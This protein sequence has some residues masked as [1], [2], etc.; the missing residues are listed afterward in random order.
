[1]D[2][3]TLNEIYFWKRRGSASKYPWQRFLNIDF[4][5]TERKRIKDVGKWRVEYFKKK[6]GDTLGPVNYYVIP[7][8]FNIP[9]KVAGLTKGN[10][11]IIQLSAL[12]NCEQLPILM[13]YPFDKLPPK[14]YS[15]IRIDNS[16]KD[17]I[18]NPISGEIEWAVNTESF[19]ELDPLDIYVDIPSERK[20]V[21]KFFKENLFHEENVAEAFQLPVS[22]AP[23]NGERGGV[24]LSYN[25]SGYLGPTS[26][27]LIKIL[28]F[29]HPPEMIDVNSI[30]PKK[31]LKGINIKGISFKDGIS[32]FSERNFVGKNYSSIFQT[33]NLGRLNEELS[34]RAKFQGEYSIS[35]DISRA[36]GES[37]TDLL[38]NILARFVRTESNTDFQ[39]AEVE[40]DWDKTK[41]LVGEDLWIQIANQRQ[42]PARIVDKDLVLD[43]KSKLIHQTKYILE[44]LNLTKKIP[45]EIGGYSKKAADNVLKIAQALARDENKKNVDEFILKKAYNIFLKNS[46]R[47]VSNENIQ[48]EA[49]KV[50]D[51]EKG[52]WEDRRCLAIRAE[53][54]IKD[55][56]IKDIFESVGYLFNNNLLELENFLEKLKIVNKIYEPISNFYR[57]VE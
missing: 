6:I 13:I 4:L 9:I 33:P 46:D 15:L 52:E 10:F 8:R 14:D 39:I 34:K 37:S 31:V 25:I 28:K 29:I 1:M 24:S 48:Y 19:E 56:Y 53:T 21:F 32:N 47:L 2:A 42:N 20:S 54:N 44:A 17:Y 49:R 11:N 55:C 35:C 51:V 26:R 7:S 43:L 41:K 5:E 12:K 27:E 3:L 45:F 23:N 30:Y 36:T 16:K 18:E 38:R 57:W 40:G 22:S 50:L